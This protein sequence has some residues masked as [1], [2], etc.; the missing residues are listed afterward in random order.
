MSSASNAGESNSA[1]GIGDSQ[2]GQDGT[3]DAELIEAT[4]DG[5]SEAYA[6]LYERHV[7]AAYNMARQVARSSSEADDFVSEAFAKLL[8]VMRGG[9]G[10]TSAFRA[11]LLTTLRRVAYDRR[12]RERK[13]QL[14]DEVVEVADLSVPF[15]DTAEAKLERSLVAQAFARL[16]ERWKTVLWHLEIE[17]QSPVEIAPLLGLSPNGVSALAY[18]AREGLRQA[19]LQV[20][21]GDGDISAPDFQHCRATVDRLGSWTRSGLSKRENAQVEAHLDSCERCRLLAAEVADVNSALRAVIAPMVLG[22][23]AAGYLTV[24]GG[25]GSAGAAGAASAGS[26]TAGQT[27]TAGISSV[28]LVVAAAFA[29]SAQ[30]EHSPVAVAPPPAAESSAPSAQVPP[31][32]GKTEAPKPEPPAPESP[33]SE[34]PREPSPTPEPRPVPPEGEVVASFPDEPV[35]LIAGGQ[36]EQLPLTLRN[37]GETPSAPVAVDITPPPGVSV[38]RTARAAECETTGD[39]LACAFDALRPGETRTINFQLRAAAD[40]PGGNITTRVDAGQVEQQLPSIGV[41]IRPGHDVTLS[42]SAEEQKTQQHS[43]IH[44]DVTNTGDV[45]GVAVADGSLPEGV[46]AF[47]IPPECDFLTRRQVRCEAELAPGESFHG[48]V[49]LTAIPDGQAPDVREVTFPVVATLGAATDRETVRTQLRFG[50][51]DCCAPGT[52]HPA[53]PESQPQEFTG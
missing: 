32:P 25:A 14:S 46:Q 8:D 24:A 10:P 40:S 18:R 31:G 3:S 20:H 9:G 50:W 49:W 36:P 41:D 1:G 21:L 35:E 23:L 19:Y 45:A 22:T 12:Q 52:T 37:T 29:I 39:G 53:L 51:T 7:H 11:Y 44:L 5:S 28:A 38:L 2:S 27:A 15:T 30:G 43:L 33:P 17:G 16:P 48:E 4:R 13:V 34:R 47:A 6:V 26:S 42:T